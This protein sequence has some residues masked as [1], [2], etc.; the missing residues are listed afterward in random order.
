MPKRRKTIFN[1]A[2]VAM[3]KCRKLLFWSRKRARLHV[4]LHHRYKSLVNRTN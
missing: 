3:V 2:T 1:M 4:I